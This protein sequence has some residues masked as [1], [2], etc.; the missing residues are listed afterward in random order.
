MLMPL[1]GLALTKSTNPLLGGLETG[2]YTKTKDNIV[3]ILLLGIDYGY[4]YSDYISCKTDFN[5]CH[6]DAIVVVSLNKTQKT[7]DLVSIHDAARPYVQ[8][9]LFRITLDAARETVRRRLL[10]R[11]VIL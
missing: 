5:E 3:N 7:V 9:E 8:T 10:A 6:T 2:N 4:E 11:N 1:S